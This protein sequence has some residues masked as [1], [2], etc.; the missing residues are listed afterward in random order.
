MNPNPLAL[1]NHLTVPLMRVTCIPSIYSFSGPNCALDPICP[2]LPLGT[3]QGELLT[4]FERG[5][6]PARRVILGVLVR[7]LVNQII[8]YFSGI[9][10]VVHDPEGFERIGLRNRSKLLSLARIAMSGSWR[11]GSFHSAPS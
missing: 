1:L 8:V 2:E 11:R 9:V 7:L 3:A 5:G 4:C 10:K 6:E